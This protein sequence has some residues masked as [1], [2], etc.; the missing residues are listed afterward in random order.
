[1]GLET[2][3]RKFRSHM[4]PL[5]GELGNTAVLLGML[6]AMFLV[7][8][9]SQLVK[10]QDGKAWPT[11]VRWIFNFQMAQTLLVR[12]VANKRVLYREAIKPWRCSEDGTAPDST[13]RQPLGRSHVPPEG[14]AVNCSRSAPSPAQGLKYR[15][16][17]T[18]GRT[19]E[20]AT[21]KKKLCA[22]RDRHGG[23]RD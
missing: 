12:V 17:S 22:G 16:F 7:N 6:A 15:T 13:V 19:I 20:P 4:E 11:I 9:A 21:Q 8:A 2:F 18:P 10:D 3:V 14:S 1:M 23:D 5:A